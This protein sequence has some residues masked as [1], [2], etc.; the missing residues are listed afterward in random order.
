MTFHVNRRTVLRSAVL[1]A[2]GLPAATGMAGAWDRVNIDLACTRCEELGK[3]ELVDQTDP[4]SFVIDDD[5][6]GTSGTKVGPTTFVFD[7]VAGAVTVELTDFY[8]KADG[9]VIGFDFVVEGGA[10]CRVDVKDGGREENE[11]RDLGTAVYGTE[12]FAPENKGGNQGAVSN[13]QFYHCPEIKVCILSGDNDIHPASEIDVT[14]DTV[15][16]G[17]W[18]EAHHYKDMHVF[19][20]GAEP[21]QILMHDFDEDGV[22]DLCFAFDVSDVFVDDP[23][24]AKDPSRMVGELLVQ[25]HASG[26]LWAGETDAGLAA[27]SPSPT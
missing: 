16:F 20:N 14:Q 22:D 8:V 13:I 18:W 9:E 6:M 10:L 15:R 24:Q 12:F 17:V 2:V 21:T 23:S 4:T 1:G 11:Y 26:D 7:A 5:W 19:D 27:L 3:L 25:N